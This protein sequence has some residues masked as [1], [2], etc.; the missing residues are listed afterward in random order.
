[1]QSK[2]L[3]GT[4]V[5]IEKT[6]VFFSRHETKHHTTT[7]ESVFSDEEWIAGNGRQDPNNFVNKLG[8]SGWVVFRATRDGQD[9][10]IAVQAQDCIQKESFE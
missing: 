3:K 4:E 1:M 8:K 10:V 6:P 7:K 9:W 2:V 5:L